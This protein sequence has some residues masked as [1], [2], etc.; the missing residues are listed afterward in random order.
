MSSVFSALAIGAH[1]V[2][3][4]DWLFLWSTIA[5][6][7]VSVAAWTLKAEAQRFFEPTIKAGLKFLAIHG[8]SSE[9][10]HMEHFRL[11]TNSLFSAIHLSTVLAVTPCFFAGGPPSDAESAA[12]FYYFP[13][14]RTIVRTCGGV[15]RKTGQ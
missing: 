6:W 2:M 8:L 13:N 1:S 11:A 14:K 9:R 3:S 10:M 4:R 15:D 12:R 5:R 7:C